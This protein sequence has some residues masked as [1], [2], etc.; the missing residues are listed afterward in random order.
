MSI[1][2]LMKTFIKNVLDSVHSVQCQE[3][4]GI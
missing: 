4:K 1:I 2:L 3:S